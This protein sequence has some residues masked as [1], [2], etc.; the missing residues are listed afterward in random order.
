MKNLILTP[1]GLQIGNKVLPCV[2]GK[3]GVSKLK[4]EG[5]SKTPVG[6]HQ[7]VG[8]LYRPDR[9]P[10]HNWAIPIRPKTFGQMTRQIL[11]QLMGSYQS[12]SI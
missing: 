12:I 10:R 6:E 3:N 9:I 2:I 11:L 4:R 7:L 5:D 1:S 8:M